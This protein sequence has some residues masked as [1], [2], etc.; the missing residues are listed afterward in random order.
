MLKINQILKKIPI[1]VISVIIIL[2]SLFGLSYLVFSQRDIL[3]NYDWKIDLTSLFIAVS[4]Y[5]VS[6]LLAV[7]IWGKII[8]ISKPNL[9]YWTNLKHYS[10]TNLGKRIPGS[11][12]YIPL[13]FQHYKD[14][15]T[16]KRSILIYSIIEVISIYYASVI[17]SAI[18]AHS[19]YKN[20]P[21]LIFIIVIVSTVFPLTVYSKSVKKILH[22]IINVEINF[23]NFFPKHIIK[24]IVYYI[25][26]RIL[27]GLFLYFVIQSIF[28]IDS[29]YI[30]YII[31]CWS[32]SGLWNLF[33]IFSPTNIGLT[34]IGLTF[35]LS[36]MIP[37]P[38]AVVVSIM[39][40]IAILFIE[41]I[42][43]I[44]ILLVDNIKKFEKCEN[45]KKKD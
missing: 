17:V 37:T 10:I 19:F 41:I 36:S 5:V 30:F 20:Y 14:Q 23:N 7:F 25:I 8:E 38:I 12:W 18:F 32:L 45:K 22:L 44:I 40:R 1:R 15:T 6:F 3:I 26:L 13:R 2:F 31:G 16:S 9:S 11:V 27:G 42:I 28:F 43:T 24:F 21:F 35:L 33:L 4:L 39:I 29:D 34:E